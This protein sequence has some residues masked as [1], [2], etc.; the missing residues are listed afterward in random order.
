MANWELVYESKL[1]QG[2]QGKAEQCD[3]TLKINLP[4]QLG[5]RSQAKEGLYAHIEELQKQG[6]IV[7][8][9]YLWEDSSA[10]FTTDYYV[11]IVA[12]ASPIVWS[13][14][15]VATLVLLGLI[16]FWTIKEIRKIAEYLGG[17][18]GKTIAS[19]TTALAVITVATV[20]GIYLVRKP[21]GG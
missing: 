1:N 17:A 8:E 12:S 14:I 3:Y 20:A 11:R 19:I 6:S 21:K 2:Y 16:A 13:I 10:T 9:Y 7:L 18:A 15:I 5:S 4:D